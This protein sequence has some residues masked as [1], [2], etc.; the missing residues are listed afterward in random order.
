MA[1]S[2]RKSA[3][4]MPLGFTIQPN[5]ATQTVEQHA[6]AGQQI[7]AVHCALRTR[8][9]Q[10]KRELGGLPEVGERSGKG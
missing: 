6:P 5:D 8:K 3:A 2:Q 9:A 7:Q 4:H 10:V 1:V